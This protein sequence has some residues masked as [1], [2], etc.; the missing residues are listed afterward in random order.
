MLIIFIYLEIDKF[1][2]N[3][4]YHSFK[5]KN[6]DSFVV[7]ACLKGARTLILALRPNG[8]SIILIIQNIIINNKASKLRSRIPLVSLISKLQACRSIKQLS[9]LL[10]SSEAY[11]F[12]ETVPA[13][14]PFTT[15]E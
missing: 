12:K 4:T 3:L 8:L 1:S 11:A 6:F 2:F 9:K 10:F 7:T 5:G 14:H 13:A 15:S